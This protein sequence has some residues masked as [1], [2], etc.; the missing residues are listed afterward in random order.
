MK[1][2]TAKQAAAFK[3][4][5]T[6]MLIELGAFP[7]GDHYGFRL[8]TMYGLLRLCPGETSIRTMFDDIPDTPPPGAS[9]NPHSGKWNFEF[10]MKPTQ[11]ELDW[12][13]TCIKGVKV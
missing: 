2:Q 5:A 9:L 4:K 6:A 13:I 7:S 1:T 11:E 8:E 10:G 3:A 12:A